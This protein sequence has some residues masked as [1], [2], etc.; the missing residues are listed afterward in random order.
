MQRGMRKWR[1]AVDVKW[2][3]T[4]KMWGNDLLGEVEK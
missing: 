4:V 1:L 2:V 3:L